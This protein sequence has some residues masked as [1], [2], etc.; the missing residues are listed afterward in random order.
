MKA[1][2]RPAALPLG[3]HGPASAS[4]A[5]SLTPL[6]GRPPPPA[7]SPALPALPAGGSAQHLAAALLP[8]PAPATGRALP[9]SRRPLCGA[10]VPAGFA[11]SA[12]AAPRAASPLFLRQLTSKWLRV[13]GDSGGRADGAPAP[14]LPAAPSPSA[15]CPLPAARPPPPAATAGGPR[16]PAPRQAPA[17]PSPRPRPAPS[18]RSGVPQ[19]RRAPLQGGRAAQFLPP[20]TA[21]LGSAPARRCGARSSPRFP[22]A[23]AAV[24]LG[25]PSPWSVRA[26]ST[27]RGSCSSRLSPSPCMATRRTPF[28]A[29]PCEVHTC[30]LLPLASGCAALPSLLPVQQPRIFQ[31]WGAAP[32]APPAAVGARPRALRLLQAWAACGEAPRPGTR[33][34]RALRHT[35]LSKFLSGKK[36]T[37]R[38]RH[39][40]PGQVPQPSCGFLFSSKFFAKGRGLKG[41]V[42]CSNNSHLFP[43]IIFWGLLLVGGHIMQEVGCAV[44]WVTGKSGAR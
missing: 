18:P 4:G 33:A 16:R 21:F 41:R 35:S 6:P 17:F 15:C 34:A 22:Q 25:A 39:S 38:S 11:R 14:T 19:R 23:C 10:P 30:P 37:R 20:A 31:P 36:A 8:C 2:S 44:L 12:P 9:R 32:A 42:I 13:P 26:I 1:R 7:T 3:R 40:L 27:K 28:L 24:G 43:A 29:S 5:A